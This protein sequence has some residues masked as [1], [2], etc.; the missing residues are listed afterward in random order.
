M[1]KGEA[2]KKVAVIALVLMAGVV[3]AADV[4]AQSAVRDECVAL[5]KDAV[6]FTNEKGVDAAIAEI[7]NKEGKFVTKNTYVFL[8]DLEGN[9]LAHPYHAMTGTP[10]SAVTA[11]GKKILKLINFKDTNGKLFV[12]EYIMLAKTKGEGWV[13]YMFPH[14]R[15]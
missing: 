5:S 9:E 2:M 11:S 4:M 12:Q 13:E 6:K 8:M 1:E 7:N 14:L 15:N 10:Y 3:L